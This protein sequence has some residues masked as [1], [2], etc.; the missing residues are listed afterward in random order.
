[1]MVPW[2]STLP[3]TDGRQLRLAP[4]VDYY[5]PSTTTAIA[6]TAATA[7]AVNS[8][9]CTI[10]PQWRRDCSDAAATAATAVSMMAD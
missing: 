4:V 7:A 9:S 8:F 2:R 10:G 6:A 1:M 3:T 5:S